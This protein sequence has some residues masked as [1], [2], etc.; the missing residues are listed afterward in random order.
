MEF[1][2]GLVLS[3]K[4]VDIMKEALCSGEPLRK[5]VQPFI[6][7]ENPP[8][9]IPLPSFEDLTLRKQDFQNKYL[10]YWYSISK[11]TGTT[12]PIDG[13]VLPSE[14]SSTTNTCVMAIRMLLI[15]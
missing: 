6:P 14:P 15:Y 12:R 1:H 8:I 11:I 13:M 10:D 7:A 9:P 5:E 4:G 2:A 3:D